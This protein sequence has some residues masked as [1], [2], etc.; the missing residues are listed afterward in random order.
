MLLGVSQIKFDSIGQV[1]FEDTTKKRIAEDL[2]LFASITARD[3]FKN[4]PIFLWLNKKDLFEKMIQAENLSVHYPDFRGEKDLMAALAYITDLFRQKAPGREFCHLKKML[5]S[6]G[7]SS[8]ICYCQG[9]TPWSK[10]CMCLNEVFW[11][12]HYNVVS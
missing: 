3:V 12:I 9:A 10:D 5:S 7:W 6:F 4:T 8:C 2:D 11:S 1:L